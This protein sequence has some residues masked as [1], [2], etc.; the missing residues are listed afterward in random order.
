MIELGGREWSPELGALK[1]ILPCRM[2]TV[3]GST[4]HPPTDSITRAIKTSKWPFEAFHFGKQSII[5]H[6]DTVHHHHAGN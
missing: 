6:F 4:Q 2:K 1:T 3:F 5:L